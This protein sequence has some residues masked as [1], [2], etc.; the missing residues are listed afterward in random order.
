[1]RCR[2][3]FTHDLFLEA[4]VVVSFMSLNNSYSLIGVTSRGYC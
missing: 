1:V 2:F 4:E 3:S